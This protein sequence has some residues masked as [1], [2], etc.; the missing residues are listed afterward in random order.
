MRSCAPSPPVPPDEACAPIFASAVLISQSEKLRT[1]VRE[2]VAA[3]DDLERALV[4]Y[5]ATG[6]RPRTQSLATV[7]CLSSSGEDAIEDAKGR[8]AKASA[9]V[10]KLSR[11]TLRPRC[12]P[13]CWRQRG[14]G[15]VA[16]LHLPTHPP[17][18]PPSSATGFVVFSRRADAHAASQ[19]VLHADRL[20]WRVTMAPPR[21]GVLWYNVGRKVERRTSAALAAYALL[22]VVTVFFTAVVAAISG[23]RAAVRGRPFRPLT[24]SHP[25]RWRPWTRSPRRCPSSIFAASARARWP[26][27]RATS[28]LWC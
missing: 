18:P 5:Q 20:Y 2:A 4:R 21:T 25:Q 12:G 22:A 17:P 16:P 1:A 23:A 13:R 24:R 6:E 26:F 11:D 3:R 7:L 27:C 9:R 10:K 8:L 14:R 19:L 28:R 15:R